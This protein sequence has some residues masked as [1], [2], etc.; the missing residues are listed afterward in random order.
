MRAMPSSAASV[1]KQA[2]AA[3]IGTPLVKYDPVKKTSC[4][5]LRNASRPTQAESAYPLAIALQ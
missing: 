2:S 4:A 1:R 3:A 5:A